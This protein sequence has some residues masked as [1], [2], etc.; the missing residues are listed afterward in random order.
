MRTAIWLTL[1][2]IFCVS[3]V[4][5]QGDHPVVGVWE[6]SRTE[7]GSGDIITPAS[8]GFT[9]QREF[10]EASAGSIYRHYVDEELIHQGQ[11]GISHIWVDDVCIEIL[12]IWCEDFVENW[13]FSLAGLDILVLVDSVFS[14][15]H[16][17]Y[18]HRRG[19]IS[20]VPATWGSVKAMY[21]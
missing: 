2:S 12:G 19:A 14:P 20:L 9:I 3:G 18:Y 4:V 17:E 5:G 16:L 1:I 10:G 11:Y 21:R 6:W 8:V 13:D 7:L 15:N